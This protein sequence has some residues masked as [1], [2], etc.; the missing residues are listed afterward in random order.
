MPTPRDRGRTHR[1]LRLVKSLPTGLD[2]EA[3]ITMYVAHQS[4]P[5]RRRPWRPNTISTRTRQLRQVAEALAPTPLIDATEDQVLDWYRGFR[6]QPN[7]ISAYGS[8][9]RG[10]YHWMCV[11]ARPRLRADNPALVLELPLVAP[12]QPRP[13]LDRHFDLALAC[14]V[15]DP[16]MYLWLGLMGCSGLR[17]CEIA[18]MQTA[19]VEPL[20]SGGGLMHVEGKGGK[21]RTVPAGEMLMLTLRPFL[22]ARGPVFTRP[23]DGRA[24]T[25]HAV[26]ARTNAFLREVGITAPHTAHS[27]R[28]RFGTDYHA[29]DPDLYRQAKVMGHSSVET[30]QRYTEVSP[31]E[32]AQYIERL[33]MRRLRPQLRGAT[34]GRRAA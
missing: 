28:H 1:E 16:E 20:E 18:W 13:M 6:G 19:G 14:S 4:Q 26:S 17:C 34:G 2:N 27:L 33:T 21:W 32:A 23:S 24:H 8:A 3:L 22:G 9:V 31:I 30:T 11:G 25:P 29:L 12:A 5:S 10:L 7:S 15:S